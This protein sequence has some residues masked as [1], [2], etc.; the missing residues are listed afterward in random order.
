M[1]NVSKRS[2]ALL[3]ANSSTSSENDTLQ[4]TQED[5]KEEDVIN[6]DE[7]PEENKTKLSEYN[8]KN[9]FNCTM[10][11]KDVRVLFAMAIGCNTRNLPSDKDPPFSKSK[12]YHTEIKPDA[13]TLK[14]EITCRWKAYH[15][16]G[17]QPCPANWKIQKCN[18]FLMANPIPSSEE[19]DLDWLASELDEWKGIQ[20]MINKSQEREDD[21]VIHRSWSTDVPFLRL[22][23]TLVDDSLQAA[24]GKAYAA[25]TREE[26][27]GRNS[28]LFQTFYEKVSNHFNNPNWI[29]HS[30]ILPDL[31]EDYTTSRPL[32]LNVAPLTP[33]EFQKNKQQQI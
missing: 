30:L 9:Y 19:V 21:Q 18:Q 33:K 7:L 22:Y 15:F 29:P 25:K 28:S 24:F 16:S 13:A 1:S 2:N 11:G 5:S 10:G 27:D 6:D 32:P 23:H 3:S 8:A 17:R 14:L 12:V 20:Q 26:L 4:A 31:H